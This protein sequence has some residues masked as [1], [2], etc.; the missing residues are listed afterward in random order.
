MH[1]RTADIHKMLHVAFPIQIWLQNT[2]SILSYK[3]PNYRDQ[4]A[5]KNTKQGEPFESQWTKGNSCKRQC[6]KCV[7][8]AG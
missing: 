6:Y 2:P 4:S 1:L 5:K 3:V 7:G 8:V